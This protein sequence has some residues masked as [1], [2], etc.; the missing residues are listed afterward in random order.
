MLGAV[1][2][3]VAPS[4]GPAA[5][6]GEHPG[7]FWTVTAVLVLAAGGIAAAVLAW[8]WRRWGPTP[9][10]HASRGEIRAELSVRAARRSAERTRPGLT[11]PGIRG[12]SPDE[13]GIPLYA[14][15]GTELRASF[16]NLTGTLAP[17][18]TGK[19]RK[20]L[21]HK[22]LEA[23]GALLCST[24]KPDLAEFAALARA[25]RPLAGPVI[26][27]DATSRLRWPAQ[28]RWSPVQGCEDQQEAARRA[29]T[30]V[31]A[32]AVRVESG[33]P[34]GAG[35]DSV[36]RERAVVVLTAYLVAAAI[37]GKDVGAILRWATVQPERPPET[38][39]APD[40][41]S[42]PTARPAARYAV[43]RAPVDILVRHGRSELAANL[44]AEMRLD[45]RTA[46]AVWMSVRRVVGAW[47]DPRL[48]ELCSPQPGRGL[49]VR[50]FIGQGGSLFIIADQQQA[51]EAV[52]VL[53]ALA[54]HWLRTAQDLALDFPERRI[55]PPATAVLDELANGTPVPRLAEV[56]SDAAGRGVV[57]HWAAQ[58]LAQLERIFGPV[59]YREVLDNTTTLSIWGGVKDERTLQWAAELCGSREVLR[60]QSHSD[61]GFG[62]GL[63][64]GSRSSTSLDTQPVLRPA[65][66]RRLPADQV[67]VL[68]R[69]MRC[70]LARVRD[71]TARPEATELAADV[72]TLRHG[73]PALDEYGYLLVK[74]VGGAVEL[75][76]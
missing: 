42:A 26:V 9:S 7:V 12:A 55:D 22:V 13:L 40:R 19:S 76:Q 44:D 2:G 45:P 62:A 30:L 3:L 48:R 43:D 50:R 11:E 18:Q 16:A 27:Y 51:G 70:F 37:E 61:G 56:V 72:E 49:D 74:R 57:I 23:P 39:V 41:R 5:V 46:S 28:L 4:G 6:V 68:H 53:T 58:S 71:V 59:G 25:R 60:R 47:T 64:G 29:F 1:T 75:P 73:A 36:F 31:E 65:E 33:A 66:I 38:A 52:P 14:A 35:N 20:D 8:W 24:T 17:T 67:L 69:G 63:L 54:E 34:G 15:G 32:A 10:G 21:V